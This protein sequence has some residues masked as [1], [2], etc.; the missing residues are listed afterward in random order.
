MKI[1]KHTVKKGGESMDFENLVVS[2]ISILSFIL[3][4]YRM[5]K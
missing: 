3:A 5:I 4:I 1:Y 2:A